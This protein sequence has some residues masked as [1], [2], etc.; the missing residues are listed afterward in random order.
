MNHFRAFPIGLIFVIATTMGAAEAQ[1]AQNAEKK[2]TPKIEIS[3]REFDFGD[4]WQ[5]TPAKKAFTIKNVGTAPLKLNVKTTCGCT[6]PT[7]PKS[8]LAPGESDTMTISYDTKNRKGR[9]RQTVTLETN[10]PTQPK[11][12]I[13]VRGNVKPIYKMEPRDGFV[14]GRLYRNSEEKRKITIVNHYD[15][16]LKFKLK[17]GD[18]GPFDVKLT[19]I[20]P[21]QKYELMARVTPPIPV[22]RAQH[23]VQL[24]TNLEELPEVRVIMY[25]FVQ[26][27]VAIR[28][29][30]LFYSRASVS[31]I[32]R[33]LRVLVEPGQEVKVTKVESTL[34]SIKV[35][36]EERP[37][38]GGE[39]AATEPQIVVT[40]PP[41]S[42]VP[43][44]AEPKIIVHTDSP[45][46][47]YQ[48]IE[49]PIRVV[50][51]PPRSGG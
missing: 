2:G 6:A 34:D 11:V 48:R 15:K 4:V 28:P 45:D 5:A 23:I 37:V 8:P 50:T 46:P 16:P 12:A 49:V 47:E 44:D 29:P 51:P 21:G 1:E 32:E 24:E 31:E 33:T 3:S 41:G 36:L 30:K 25:A 26:A 39:R 14:F 13:A 7:K 22:G 10:D 43:A 17:P 42:E 19:E 18:Q 9:A 20:E 38:Q 27:P 40:F 35:S